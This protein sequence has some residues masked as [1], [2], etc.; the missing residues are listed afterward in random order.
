MY[1]PKNINKE[2]G[3]YKI[4]NTRTG[5]FYIGSTKNAKIRKKTHFSE[6][7]RN[8]HHCDHLQKAFN[9]EIDKGIFEFRMFIFCKES[10][11]L[12]I[13]QG[14]ID[15]MKPAYNTNKIAGK[16]PV[17][18]GDQNPSKRPEVRE[19]MRKPKTPEHSA[20]VGAALRGRKL[21]DEH[22][23]K[24]SESHKGKPSWN[25]GKNLSEE[26]KR[27]L[28]AARKG[29]S[30]PHKS[31]VTESQALEILASTDGSTQI[32][33]RLGISRQVVANI[34]MGHTWRHL[35]R[36]K[37]WT[38][39]ELRLLGWTPEKR[40]KVSESVRGTKH[41]DAKL[42]ERDIIQI[43]L[44]SARHVDLAKKYGV[45]PSTII[46]VRQGKTWRHVDATDLLSQAESAPS[47]DWPSEDLNYPKASALLED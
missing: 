23:K 11:L 5:K 43:R 21:S 42:N 13:E 19:K 3:V 24:L 10:E 45:D 20:K 7:R 32:A 9:K 18:V 14:C 1:L 26:H 31:S 44:S 30:A 22:R 40:N 35:P 36:S 25:T 39:D 33:N 34:R 38:R 46:N 2:C 17:M 4:I 28:S 29:R 8:I 47:S 37:T 6:L 41:R 12:A 15:F 16:P 27:K